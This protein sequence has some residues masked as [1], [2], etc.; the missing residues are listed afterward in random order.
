MMGARTLPCLLL[1]LG[2]ACAST[3]GGPGMV[4]VELPHPADGDELAIAWPFVVTHAGGSEV[5]ADFHLRIEEGGTLLGVRP[6]TDNP[7]PDAT[8]RWRG[9]VRN[10]EGYWIGDVLPR[11]SNVRLWALLRPTPGREPRLRVVHWPTDGRD[12]P[13][14]EQVCEIWLYDTRAQKTERQSC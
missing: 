10:G 4:S 14:A 13:I 9:E 6:D 11:G 2:V 8:V 12:N 3:P 5:V 1:S 7:D